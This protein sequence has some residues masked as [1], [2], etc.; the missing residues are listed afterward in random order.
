MGLFMSAE[1]ESLLSTLL[2]ALPQLSTKR[3]EDL[4]SGATEAIFNALNKAEEDGHLEG[5][6]GAASA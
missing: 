2:V 4:L 3:R 1:P 6:T 5:A